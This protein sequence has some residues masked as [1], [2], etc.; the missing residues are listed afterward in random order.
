MILRDG[1]S[2]GAQVG[3]IQ[4]SI[5]NAQHPMAGELG[6]GCSMLDVGCFGS[7]SQGTPDFPGLKASHKPL[8]MP[9]GVGRWGV[10]TF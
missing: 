2:A 4:H 8:D 6:V 7:C 3:N 10:L 1:P 9:A 5:S